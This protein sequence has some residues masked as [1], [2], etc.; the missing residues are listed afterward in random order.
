MFLVE[1]LYKVF[2]YVFKLVK[3]NIIPICPAITGGRTT[4]NTS[5]SSRR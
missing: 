2:Q 3:Y 5:L 1:S 4:S